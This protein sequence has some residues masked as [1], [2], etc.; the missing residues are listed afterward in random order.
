MVPQ[1]AADIRPIKMT[2]VR[3]AKQSSSPSS[4]MYAREINTTKIADAIL[5]N[6]TGVRSNTAVSNRT[7][8][9]TERLA[10][11]KDSR[12]AWM[13]DPL[14]KSHYRKSLDHQGG[15]DNGSAHGER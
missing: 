1:T 10:G 6:G 14:K 9:P 11:L 12:P 7:V 2:A 8:T 4:S 5:L 3:R 15:V 13:N